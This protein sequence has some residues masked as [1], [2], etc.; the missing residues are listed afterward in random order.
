VN[1]L[2]EAARDMFGLWYDEYR[3]LGYGNCAQCGAAATGYMV[4][5]TDEVKCEHESDCPVPVWRAAIASATEREAAVEELVRLVRERRFLDE[6]SKERI[7][8]GEMSESDIAAYLG[9]T[10]ENNAKTDAA[11]AALSREVKP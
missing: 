5:P 9:A 1:P 6:D 4:K 10:Y 3:G 7:E 11:L 2:L 8:R